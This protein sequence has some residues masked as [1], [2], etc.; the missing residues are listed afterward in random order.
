MNICVHPHQKDGPKRN[1]KPITGI[2]TAATGNA[3]GNPPTLAA[4]SNSVLSSILLNENNKKC[5]S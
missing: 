3:P 2:N 4:I 5:L 1:N